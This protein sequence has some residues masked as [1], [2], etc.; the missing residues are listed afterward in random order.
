MSLLSQ[1]HLQDEVAA[2]TWV[3]AHV[4]PNGPVCPHCQ[5]TERISKMQGKATRI[6]LYKCYSCRK[7]FRV[8]VGTIFEKSHV[9]M[10]LWLQA[11]YLMAG[12]KK[13]ISSNQLHRTLGITLKSAW[14][15]SHRIRHAMTSGS[16]TAPPLGGEGSS[17]IVEADETFIGQKKGVPKRRAYHHK[18]A[19]MSLVERGGDLRSFHIEKANAENVMEVVRT[20]VDKQA[21]VM[22]DEAKYYNQIGGEF[23]EHGTVN[24]SAGEYVKGDA[25]VNTLEN[26]YSVFK[27]G[28]KGVYQHCS[29][30]HLHRYVDEFGF[31]H[32]NRVGRGVDDSERA[33]RMVEGVVGKRLTYRT[34]GK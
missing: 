6:G 33:G 1:K 28:M 23:A 20:N 27:R 29:E 9:P 22:T 10:H 4:W 19:V 21:R 18:H 16:L 5:S 14:F 25:H 26:F 15:L 17:G 13:G 7:Q 12:S 2:Y 30:K 8:T 34:T 11:F 24:H 31:R 3:E 32:N